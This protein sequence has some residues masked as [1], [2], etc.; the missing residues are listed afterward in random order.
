MTDDGEALLIKSSSLE[1]P[2]PPGLFQIIVGIREDGNH[3]YWLLPMTNRV[4]PLDTWTEK[5]SFKTIDEIGSAIRA[6]PGNTSVYVGVP[7]DFSPGQNE[8]RRLTKAEIDQLR[9]L[10]RE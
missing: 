1:T 5:D 2:G 7:E 4:I 10:V 6:L 3:V 8:I 9:R